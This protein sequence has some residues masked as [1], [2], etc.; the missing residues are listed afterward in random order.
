G[1]NPPAPPAGQRTGAVPPGR[2][3][4]RAAEPPRPRNIRIRRQV[5]RARGRYDRPRPE[6]LWLAVPDRLHVPPPA[7]VVPVHPLDRRAVPDVLVQL[8]LPRAIP[9]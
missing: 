2:M 9:Q 3:E 4:R 1:T 8:V 7:A 5:Q 6:G